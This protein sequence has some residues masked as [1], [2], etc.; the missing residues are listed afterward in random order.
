MNIVIR[1][2]L[3]LPVAGAL[4]D[5]EF[6][7]TRVP[8]IGLAGADYAGIRPEIL[9]EAGQA[10]AS[11]TP[12]FRDRKRPEIVVTSPSS[13][14]I[15]K[16][17]IGPQRRLSLL[18][19]IPEGEDAVRFDLAGAGTPAGLRALMQQAGLWPALRSRPFDRIPAPDA[20]PAAVFV[21][22]IDTRPHAPDPA[23]VLGGMEDS[24]ARG[25]SALSL[26]T[27]AQVYV[28][29]GDGV[30]LVEPQDRVSVVRFTGFHP[31]GL[32]GTH[33]ARLHP[34]TSSAPVWHINYQDV[35]ALGRLLARGTVDF[36]RSISLAGPG[37][38]QPLL[39]RVPIGAD[40]HALSRPQ[41]TPGPKRILSGAIL[42]GREAQ[43]LSRYHLQASVVARIEPRARN[44][45]IAA[46]GRAS[47]PAAFVPTAAV[48][49]ALGPDMPAV[50]LLRA[51]SIGDADRAAQLGCLQLGEDDLALATYA[52]GGE[53]D[54]GARLRAVLD[55]LEA[56]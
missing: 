4:P 18:T 53:T 38:Q 21:T 43:F 35:A 9:V 7:P 15:E 33:I 36:S 41:L 6:V 37:T 24:F 30:D 32:P 44:W 42:D 22:A 16:I 34:A 23:L 49:R 10:V 11:G 51:L 26:L 3:P 27:Q 13:G 50:P 31:A 25:V 39:L 29:Q 55:M 20:E 45:L 19:I 46:L 12:L 1:H 17:E 54:F 28:C 8:R 52:T 14:R 40:L 48:D 56:A 5:G 47:A 2:G